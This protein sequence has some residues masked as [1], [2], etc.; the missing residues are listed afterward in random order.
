MNFV[1]KVSVICV[2]LCVAFCSAIGPSSIAGLCTVPYLKH[3]G[4]LNV[5]FPIDSSQSVPPIICYQVYRQSVNVVKSL[6]FG[7]IEAD[8]PAHADCLTKEFGDKNDVEHILA[9]RLID[10][11]EFLNETEKEEQLIAARK[12]LSDELD[13]ISDHCQN[14]KQA[15]INVFTVPLGIK[16]ET[17]EAH[18]ANYC[19]A[20][21]AADNRIL[22]FSNVEMNPHNIDTENVNCDNVIDRQKAKSE[23]EIR[24]AVLILLR[25]ERSEDCTM[26]AYKSDGI[27]KIQLAVQLLEMYDFPKEYKES[28]TVSYGNGM[29]DF[30]S[31]TVPECVK[32]A[33]E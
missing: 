29:L 16:N 19:L 27:F 1:E 25:A 33:K 13:R 30:I 11:T 6:F 14:D 28:A 2:V 18:Q 17:V 3:S 7:E 22:D 26:N 15:F 20:K 24:N 4:R 10:D 21:Y 31:T 8:L 9:I 12:K 32:K 23:R 5:N